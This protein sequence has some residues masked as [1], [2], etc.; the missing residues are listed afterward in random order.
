ME[1]Q[2]TDP[3]GYLLVHFLEDPDGYAERI[4]MDLSDGDNPHRWI[5]LNGGE[6]LLTSTIGTTGFRNATARL[7]ELGCRRIAIIGVHEWE[8]DYGSSPYRLKG[9]R[10]ALAAAGLP[11]DPALE[12]PAV[13]WY[14][15]DGADAV[16]RMLDG[17]IRP[18]GIVCMNDLLA[19]GAMQE[20][21]RRGICVP[22]DV[23]VIG[24][25][26]STDSQYL[27]PSLS[28]VDPNLREVARMSLELLCDRIEGRVPEEAGPDGYAEV[29]VPSRLVERES[30]APDSLP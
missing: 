20:L 26:D 4:Y 2:P 7:I 16:A 24:Y 22:Q 14:Q 10:Q 13:I 28:S 30:S 17:G 15:P 8:Q 21:A 25:D 12:I 1:A 9:Y 29:V 18:D 6:P 23:K 3:Y 19:M 5:P 27:S 11:N